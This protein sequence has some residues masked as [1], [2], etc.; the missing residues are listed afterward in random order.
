M[1]WIQKELFL[2][3]VQTKQNKKKAYK[4]GFKWSTDMSY[5]IQNLSLPKQHKITF[6]AFRQ[7]ETI[8]TH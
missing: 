7:D 8:A 4:I 1:Q 5:S 2:M 3:E 6:P